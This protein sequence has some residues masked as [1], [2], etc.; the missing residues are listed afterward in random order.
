MDVYKTFKSVTCTTVKYGTALIAAIGSAVMTGINNATEWRGKPAKNHP[1][2]NGAI[3]VTCIAAG[4]LA[5]NRLANQVGKRLDKFHD[6]IVI[7]KDETKKKEP[8][9]IEDF[10]VDE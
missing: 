10:E 1:F 9:D 4:A 7:K 5:G 3:M 8:I 6:S 2:E